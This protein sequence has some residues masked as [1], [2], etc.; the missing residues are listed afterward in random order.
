M[1]VKTK[2]FLGPIISVALFCAAGWLLHNELKIYQFHEIRGYIDRISSARIWAGA[3]LT[4]LSYIV[5]TGYD[6]LALQYIGHPLGYR[7]TGLASFIGYAFS[8]NIGLSMIA[9]ASVRYRLYTA[10]GLSTLEIAQVVLFC[11]LTLWLGFLFLGG[12]IFIL[13]PMT[14]P[15]ALHIPFG[16][17]HVLGFV[18]LGCVAA[19][20]WFSMTA[21][22][23]FTIK[24]M[25]LKVP[26]MSVSSLQIGVAVLDWVIAGGVLYVL[27]APFGE[28][29]F[30]S[31]LQIF[32]LAQF[33][34][35][36]S[37]IPGGMGVF[38]T[39]MVTLLSTRI[40]S[41]QVFASLVVYRVLYY[42]LAL[43]LAVL[44]LGSQEAIRHKTVSLKLI[45][46]FGHWVSPLLPQVLGF[47]YM[48]GG[49][50]LMF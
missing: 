21:R 19:Y 26:P 43:F 35:L 45:E 32:M 20:A 13:E 16:S 6:V 25:E 23:T 14:L 46:I 2:Q 34:G 12:A 24:E 10:W 49:A 9:G 17:L 15:D 42:W 38:E 30:L 44:L 28:Y 41:A 37:Q 47:A 5:M 48:V 50:I 1:K 40:P 7:K 22:K 36:I 4:V 8:N 3:G 29:S 39:V 27:L 18:M 31:F 33:L 11:T